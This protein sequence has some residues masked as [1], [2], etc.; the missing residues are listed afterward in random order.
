MPPETIHSLVPTLCWLDGEV[1]PANAEADLPA[2]LAVFLNGELHPLVI[3]ER[4]G[5]AFG[6]RARSV[7]EM[8]DLSAWAEDHNVT[9]LTC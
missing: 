7:S 4:V 2:R 8:E 6:N 3:R 9:S 5:C 1:C